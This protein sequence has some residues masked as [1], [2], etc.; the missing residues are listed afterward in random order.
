MRRQRS[1]SLVSRRCLVTRYQQE[2]R[3]SQ[4]ATAA[5]TFALPGS[6]PLAVDF[7]GGRLT[8]DGGWTWVAEADGALEL[9]ETLAA[10]VPDHWRRRRHTVLALL[11]QRLYQLAAG[12]ADQNDADALR[13]DPLLKLV[14]GRLPERDP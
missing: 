13:G 9:S 8:S 1:P 6:L 11:R 7:H 4:S 3:M 10:A 14:C 12:Y 2:P 5:F